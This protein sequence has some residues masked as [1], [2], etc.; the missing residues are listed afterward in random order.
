[1]PVRN[2]SFDVF[3]KKRVKQNTFPKI[4]RPQVAICKLISNDQFEFYVY[5]P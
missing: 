5:L 2:E 4:L 3:F 1:M